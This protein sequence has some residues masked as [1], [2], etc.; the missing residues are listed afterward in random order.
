MGSKN[1]DEIY[2]LYG[3]AI[4]ERF[5]YTV[6]SKKHPCALLLKYSIYGAGGD[7]ILKKA[8]LFIE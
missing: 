2:V 3:I 5:V 1:I 7:T 8:V 6:L 4:Y